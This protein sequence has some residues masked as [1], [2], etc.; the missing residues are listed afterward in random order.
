MDVFLD[1]TGTITDMN[2]ENEAFLRMCKELAK[3]F[4]IDIPAKILAE[5]IKE[6]RRPFMERRAEKYIPIRILIAKAVEKIIGKN[7][8][9]EEREEVYRIY[10]DAHAKY[11]LLADGTLNALKSIRN[12]VQVMGIVT[13][14]DT[15]YTMKVLKSLK[16]HNLFDCVITAEDAGVGKPNPKIFQMAINCG[17]SDPRIFIGDSEKRD[18]KGAKKVG[19]IT[20]KIGKRTEEG[21]FLAKNLYEAAEIIRKFF[22][23][24]NTSP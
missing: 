11:V 2:S 16:I 17:K 9:E 3:K 4:K 14:A 5:R 21:D 15:P 23:R 13:D 8:N 22:Y 12:M 20:I 6:Y 1:M 10:E 7:L 19:F 24:D 18:I